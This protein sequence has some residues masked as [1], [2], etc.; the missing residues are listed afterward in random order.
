MNRILLLT[1]LAASVLHGQ[2]YTRGVGVYPGDSNQDFAPTLVPDTTT[3]RNL[4]LHRPAYQSSAYD[5]NL[6]AQLVT[7]GIKETSLPRWIA[8]STSQQ[9]LL[10][11]NQREL[12]LDHNTV[13]TVELRG[14]HAWA[15]FELAGGDSPLEVDRIAVEAR[16]QADGWTCAVSASDDAQ[17]WKELGRDSGKCSVPFAAPA[18]ARF[19]RVEFDAPST[20][21]WR[22][23]EVAFFRENRRVEPGRSEEH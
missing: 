20:G 21:T 8:T 9:G 19:Y 5:Y 1:L 4:A 12:M 2:P 15:Q 16:T 23:A 3:Y 6:T 14:T 7:D 13:S 18:H 10:K 22:V 17:E 11:K